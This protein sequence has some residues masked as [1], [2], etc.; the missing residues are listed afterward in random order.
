MIMIGSDN[1]SIKSTN[2]KPLAF[3]TDEV[4]EFLPDKLEHL[5]GKKLLKGGSFLTWRIGL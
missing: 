2:I 1:Y 5:K 4:C 3:G